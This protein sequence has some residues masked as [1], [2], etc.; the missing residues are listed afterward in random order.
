MRADENAAIIRR[1]YEAFNSGDMET[2]TEIFDERAVWHLPGRS[3]LADDYQGRE[4]TF[5]YFGRLGQETGGSF[6]AE[7]ERLLADDDDRVVG[8][9]HNTAEREGKQLDDDV[10]LVFQ[11]KD[12]RVTEGSG[13]P[14]RSLH[15]GR[16]LVIAP[17]ARA[18]RI[19]RFACS[20]AAVAL[21][22]HTRERTRL[23]RDSLVSCGGPQH[24]TFHPI[25]M[26]RR[27]GPD[28]GV[29]G[30]AR[31]PT[32]RQA[33]TPRSGVLRLR[34]LVAGLLLVAATAVGC[35][36]SD[37]DKAQT[38]VC[39]ASDDIEQQVDKLAGLTPTTA[40][41]DSVNE[42]L[43]AIKDDLKQIDDAQG[44]LSEERKQEVDSTNQDFTAE[45]EG[46][47]AASRRSLSQWGPGQAQGRG[48]AA[49]EFVRADVRS[50]RLR[51]VA[52]ELDAGEERYQRPISQNREK[53][54]L[55]L[56]RTGDALGW[57]PGV[58]SPIPG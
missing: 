43:S 55:F 54:G 20:I 38:Q 34:F 22:F 8:I 39:D 57:A 9:H 16:L 17:R 24:V 18:W 52:L 29:R 19:R 33:L 50:D 45:L 48:Q 13:A 6:R 53:I 31:R 41:V 27:A 58:S 51:I 2:L 26:R 21:L 25:G 7:L 46:S 44:N 28:D 11:L 40:T 56:E 5:A 12:G 32:F 35:G 30:M 42:G 10:C 23:P 37:A 15:L 3:S 49:S 36:E 47:Q 1:G 14:S 4:A